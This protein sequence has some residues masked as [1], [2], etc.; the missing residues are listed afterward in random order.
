M[1]RCML[2][3]IA[4]GTTFRALGEELDTDI[5]GLQG[6]FQALFQEMDDLLAQPARA[7]L[8]TAQLKKKQ[9]ERLLKRREKKLQHRIEE[10]ALREQG[11]EGLALAYRAAAEAE[12]E[13]EDDEEEYDDE[14]SDLVLRVRNVDILARLPR[15]EQSISMRVTAPRKGGWGSRGS[16]MSTP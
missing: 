9:E 3:F 5:Q 1:W 16:R 4:L 10:Q 7:S 11:S 8:S 14:D 13:A 12:A 2:R 15:V 6:W